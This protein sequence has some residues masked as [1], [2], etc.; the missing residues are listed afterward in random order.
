M[1]CYVIV[2]SAGT[3]PAL[4]IDSILCFED[5]TILGKVFI[6]FFFFLIFY[7]SNFEQ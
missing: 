7:F 1:D 4:D 3:Q 5:R 2:Q 6:S